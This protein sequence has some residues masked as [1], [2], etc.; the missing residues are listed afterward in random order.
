[1]HIQEWRKKYSPLNQII[2][3][4]EIALKLGVSNS[5]LSY[6]VKAGW[7]LEDKK[8]PKLVKLEETK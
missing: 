5:T 4:R 1:M 2:E 6:R 3:L 8:R 7:G